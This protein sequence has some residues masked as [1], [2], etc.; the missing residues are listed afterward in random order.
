M[1]IVP[2]NITTHNSYALLAH[3]HPLDPEDPQASSSAP[4]TA[5]EAQ[6]EEDGA[7]EEGGSL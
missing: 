7:L 3:T 5:E 2:P 6:G 4:A 1:P